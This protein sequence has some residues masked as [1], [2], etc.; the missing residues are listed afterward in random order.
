MKYISLIS[1]YFLAVVFLF[2]GVDKLFHYKGFVTALSSYL[3]VPDGAAEYLALPLILCEIWIALGLLITPWRKIAALMAVGA[4][5]IFTTALIVNHI[6]AP[7]AVC[8]CWFSI[9]L[10]TAT[11][12]HILMNLTLLGLAIVIWMD[13]QSKDNKR[14]PPGLDIRNVR[15]NANTETEIGGVV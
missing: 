6:Y 15:L 8:G 4:M 9:T 12:T 13:G 5:A 3:V 1:K 11:L 14:C 7:E 2:T 10:G